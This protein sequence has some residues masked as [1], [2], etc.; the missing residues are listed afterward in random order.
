MLE[1]E[2]FVWL[3]SEAPRLSRWALSGWDEDAKLGAEMSVLEISLI[4]CS[5]RRRFCMCGRFGGALTEG[6]PCGGSLCKGMADLGLSIW[7][8]TPWQRSRPGTR[9]AQV[10]CGCCENQEGAV[11]ESGGGWSQPFGA[12]ETVDGENEAR[13]ISDIRQ[14]GTWSN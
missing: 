6:P 4:V 5:V 14:T 9:A 7:L 8:A 12:S 3:C 11:R 13:D 1:L 2:D 10:I